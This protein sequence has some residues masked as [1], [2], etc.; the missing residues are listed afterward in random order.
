MRS[1]RAWRGGQQGVAGRAASPS[2]TPQTLWQ[3]GSQSPPWKPQ[4]GIIPGAV[5]PPFPDVVLRCES[6]RPLSPAVFLPATPILGIAGV[7][8]GQEA[9]S[10][11]QTWRSRERLPGRAGCISELTGPWNMPGSG[12]QDQRGREERMIT[13]GS[14]RRAGEVVGAGGYTLLFP[15]LVHGPF[16]PGLQCCCRDRRSGVE[17]R[18]H[19]GTARRFPEG[20]P[21]TPGPDWKGLRA[22][23]T[24]I[25]HLLWS[26]PASHLFWADFPLQAPASKWLNSQPFNK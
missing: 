20:W 13:S 24:S 18:Q 3:P 2:H 8:L 19:V 12:F 5:L 9:G 26:P 6:T 25:S 11:G 1:A 4:T 16:R 15:S 10:E 23:L 17:R 22:S 14:Q 7:F 21:L